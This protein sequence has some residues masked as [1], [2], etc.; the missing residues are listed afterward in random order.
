MVSIGTFLTVG[1]IAGASV[2][3]YAV[4]RNLDK[5]GGALARGTQEK[6]TDPFSN[7][8]ENL[9]VSSPS[10]GGNAKPANAPIPGDPSAPAFGFIPEAVAQTPTASTAI[11]PEYSVTLTDRYGAVAQEKAK[12]VLEMFAPSSQNILI[13]K[14]TEIA[15]KSPTPLLTQA[16]S[17]VDQARVSVGGAKPLT[18]KFY[19][20]FSL[21]NKP[22]FGG[23]TLPLSREAVQYYGKTGIVAREVY[24]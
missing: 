2:L 19:Q 4:Y 10:N 11:T 12:V 1:I 8:L 13:K 9:F 24:L 15:K 22:L 6:L 16:Y 23:R 20:L 14:S 18:N 3:G 21:A 17:I 7:Y 5:V